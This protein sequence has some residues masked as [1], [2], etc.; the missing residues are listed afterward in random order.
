[1]DV[2]VYTFLLLGAA[3]Y[4]G[5]LMV[6]LK[7]PEILGEI[8]GG[9]LVGPVALLLLSLIFANE[10]PEIVRYFS[11]EEASPLLQSIIDYAAVFIMLG[12]GLEIDRKDL[13]K[14]GKASI[15][16]AIFGVIVPFSMGFY[17]GKVLLDL[18]LLASL[19]IATALSITAV[20][21][22]VATLIQLGK[23]N[24]KPGIT[25]IG[26]AV[27]DDILG[28]IIL[29]VL[30]SLKNGGDLESSYL[31]LKFLKALVF[32]GVSITAG[33]WIGRFVF[34]NSENISSNERLSLVLIWV[35]VFSMAAHIVNLHLMIGAF[36]GGLTAREYLRSTEVENIEQWI[37][38]FFAP[39]FFA[40]TGFS[41]TLSGSSLGLSLLYIVLAAFAG[42]II[43]GSIGAIL[44]GIRPKHSIIVG[45]GMNG[46]AAV[47]LVIANIALMEGIISREIY[48]SIVF[49]AIITAVS[50]PLLLNLSIKKLKL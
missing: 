27:V 24:T 1:M 47:E 46:R 49:M 17:V 33:P 23:L 45:I 22:S 14:A 13:I 34:R 11:H 20:A 2:F 50:T 9:I 8:L 15:L 36:L 18:P 41:V 40:W 16:T 32:I 5:H 21:L 6:R 38:G 3:T 28:I 44:G 29:S 42:K 39:L 10:K 37:W 26:A 7:Q 4:M 43:G 31:L 30:T 12:A 19:Y 35:F 25:I 48:S